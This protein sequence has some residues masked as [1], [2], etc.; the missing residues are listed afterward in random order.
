MGVCMWDGGREVVVAR[1]GK[2]KFTGWEICMGGRILYGKSSEKFKWTETSGDAGK[3]VMCPDWLTVDRYII[4]VC[5]V[6]S[7]I[8]FHSD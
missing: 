3:L 1:A 7:G 6:S 8:S 2:K 4:E 5:D